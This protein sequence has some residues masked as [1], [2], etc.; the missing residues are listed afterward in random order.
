MIIDTDF[1]GTIKFSASLVYII[2]YNVTAIVRALVAEQ[3]RSL[4]SD[5]KPYN[6]DKGSDPDILFLQVIQE[7]I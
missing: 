2:I 5:H 7:I 1:I 6:T 3:L 4:I